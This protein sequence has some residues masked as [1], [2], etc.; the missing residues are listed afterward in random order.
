MKFGFRTKGDGRSPTKKCLPQ[1]RERQ[2]L[3]REKDLG[4]ETRELRAFP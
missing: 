4:T 2:F 1:D 3:H